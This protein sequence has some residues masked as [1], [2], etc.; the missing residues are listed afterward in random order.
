MFA[1]WRAAGLIV[2]SLLTLALLPVLIGLG[3]WQWHRKAWKEDLIAKIEARTT[4]EPVSYPAALAQYIKTG[5]VEYLHVRVTGT[6]DYSQERHLYAP[7]PASQGWHIYTLLKPEGGLPPV[8]VNR[9]WVP[10]TLKD[11]SKRAQGQVAGPVTVTG[12]VR[13]PEHKGW[14][15][16]DNDYGGNR[17]YWRDLGAMQGELRVR[18]LRCSSMPRNSK[19]MLPSRSTL[20]RLRQ[21]R[22]VG[23]RAA[24]RG[25]TY[26]IHIYSMS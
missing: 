11:P 8:F 6:Y 26:P 13:L 1:R 7:T 17:W 12:L 25:S 5:D 3:N 15:T 16:P 21:I 18:H 19:P 20:M 22:V 24:R 10:D 14:F 4:A 23:R 9:G 2:P